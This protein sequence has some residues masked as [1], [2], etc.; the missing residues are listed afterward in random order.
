ML[1]VTEF[2]NHHPGGKFVLRHLSGTDVSKFFYGGYS[3]QNLKHIPGRGNAHSNY[4]RLIANE[5]T[6]AFYE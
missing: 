1:D 2:I 6:I 3:F 5:L 4:A